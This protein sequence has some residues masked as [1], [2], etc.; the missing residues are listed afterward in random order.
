MSPRIHGTG[1]GAGGAAAG[2]GAE[3]AT[4]VAGVAA[5][6]PSIALAETDAATIALTKS[7]RRIVVFCSP[8]NVLTKPQGKR[9]LSR[10]TYLRFHRTD[11]WFVWVSRIFALHSTQKGKSL[12]GEMQVDAPPARK[13]D[14]P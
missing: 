7:R 8:L 6:C 5:C 2:G 12:V 14:N 11:V 4:A 13:R 10:L 9:Q 1:P 3:G